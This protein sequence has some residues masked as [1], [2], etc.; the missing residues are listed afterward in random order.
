[1]KPASN[2][3]PLLQPVFTGRAALLMAALAY[4]SAS[5]AVIQKAN[6]ATD[7]NLAG[8]WTGGVVPG[9]AD[10]A[11][12][13]STVTGANSV[14]L[15]ADL[16]WTGIQIANP[17]GAVTVAG[18]NT[19]TLGTGGI[20]LSTATQDLTINAGL[21]LGD[22]KHRTWN[23][24][25]GRIL[26]LG[27]AVIR[28]A[29]ATVNVSGTGTVNTPL[30][31]TN[32][33]VGPWLT[34]GG[35]A[36]ATD[37]GGFL[38]ALDP[39]DSGAVSAVP[40]ASGTGNF[41]VS[42][43]GTRT[44]VLTVNTIRYTGAGAATFAGSGNNDFIINGLMN[45]GAGT[46]IITRTG[47]GRF[48]ANDAVN[49]EIVFNAATGDINIQSPFRAGTYGII[50]TGPNVVLLNNNASDGYTGPTRINQGIL[51][52]AA[53]T[54]TTIGNNSAVSLSDTAGAGL[55][56]QTFA[57]TI[58][59]LAGGGANGGNVT[60]TT[61]TLTIAG[62]NASPVSYGGSLAL[63]TAGIIK[64]GPGTQI[65][66]GVNTYTGTT[67][68]QNGVLQIAGG[69]LASPT[70]TLGNGTTSGKLVLGGSAGPVNQSFAT[71]STSGT[72]TANAVVGGAS[73]G[74]TLGLANSG[75]FALTL[76]GAGTNESNLGV[77]K[78]GPGTLSLTGSATMAGAT[79]I[80]EGM[81]EFGGSTP[82]NQATTG[83]ITVADSAALG[84]KVINPSQTRLSSGAL[85][86]GSADVTTLA[87]DFGGLANPTAPVINAAG[88][89]AVPG[90]SVLI[91]TNNVVGLTSGTIKLI[92]YTGAALNGTQFSKFILSNPN[93]GARKTASLV[94]NT[95]GTS[96]DLLVSADNPTWRGTV[97]NGQ[98]G[99]DWDIDNIGDGSV[100]T[101]NWAVAGG[102]TT[103]REIFPDNDSVVFDDTATGS[104]NVNIVAAVSPASILVNNAAKTYT[105][106]GANIGG[107][108]ILTKSGNG[109]LILANSGTAPSGG[110]QITGGTVK[111]G[112]FFS[113]GGQVTIDGGSFDLNGFDT[114]LDVLAGAGGSITNSAAGASTLTIGGGS[115]YTGTITDGGAGKTLAIT[116]NA[117][118]VALGGTNTYSG[119]TTLSG[120][121]LQAN[122]NGAL[123]S[124]AI[125]ISTG[126][127]FLNNGVNL[128][129]PLTITGGGVTG[130]GVVYVPTASTS[131]T[132]SGPINITGAAN[133]GGHFAANSTGG[134]LN[135]TGVITS[136]VPVSVRNGV[137]VFSN[138][139]SSYPQIFNNG[140]GTIRLGANNAIPTTSTVDISNVG[141]LDLAGFNQTLPSITSSGDPVTNSVV[142]TSTLTTT[143][144]YDFD[145][146]LQNGGT[147][148]LLALNVSSGTVKLLRANT[149]TGGTTIASG[150]TV[151]VN[152]ANSV[153][154]TG[155]NVALSGTLDLSNGAGTS[156]NLS[157]GALSG[158]GTVT[159]SAAGAATFTSGGATN[160]SFSGVIQNG[161]GVTSLTK[162]GAGILELS[163][164][165]TYS[166]NTQLGTA[167]GAGGI[168]ASVSG[169]LGSGTLLFDGSGGAAPGGPTSRLELVNGITLTNAISLNQRNNASAAI[170]NVSGS[171]T[172]SGAIDIA[173]GGAQANIQSDAGQL[174]LS[175][176]IATSIATVRNLHLG[177]AGNGAANGIISNGASS[178]TVTKEGSGTWT[179]TAANTYTGTTTVSEGTLSI[180]QAVLAD[181]AAVNIATAGVLNLTHGTSDTVDSL[182]IDGV[183]QAAGT[184]GSLSSSATNKTARITGSG[185]L[186]VSKGAVPGG[187]STWAS[188]SGL[189]TGVNDGA[190]QNPDNDGFDNGTEYILGGNPL[191]GSNNPKVYTFLADTEADVDALKELV[192]TIAVPAGTPAF[193]TAAPSTATFDGFAI[194]VRGGTDLSSFAATVTP[195]A[196]VTTGLPAAPVQGG[197]TY[198][199]RS[200]S[201]G[202]SNG[203]PTKGFLQVRVTP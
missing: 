201:L 187:F 1:M 111:L 86:F 156:I 157:V 4:S 189:T 155:G 55:D 59:S 109:T 125:S 115:T 127:L 80:A 134:V 179:L 114:T 33:I 101:P 36:W 154:G 3:Y 199:Y 19:L 58:G 5:A 50:K 62:N 203:T 69:S 117:G 107:S 52:I 169:A 35:S 71:V 56:L 97:S 78:T 138:T 83:N 166:G 170:L 197:I 106:S 2:S 39:A 8:S 92:D 40:T 21:T 165:N 63:G 142:G 105:I 118:A 129:N 6:N 84:V 186:S 195:V 45:S 175:G 22:N 18:A 44:G 152:N 99:A 193:T 32:G 29:G 133:A 126:Q 162:S 148:M 14:N 90:S 139:G 113:L 95:A 96:L 172:L 100:G 120:G 43:G 93:L 132:Y 108:G 176:P 79:S 168:R 194:Q 146:V 87:V 104:T 164:A 75:T 76:G 82:G 102:P 23:I 153:G 11:S 54:N 122:S 163:N 94:N 77:V 147:D 65:L 181:A 185:I 41:D 180:S 103:Y 66:T 9:S 17:G 137:V 38:A 81:L 51:R 124:G 16:S 136:T 144:T 31:N 7:L 91:N 145:G 73:T 119:G 151:Q 128:S 47:S 24:P 200:F 198:E 161:A 167:N 123:G 184:W 53:S 46:L 28:S 48:R 61:A 135:I 112:A 25:A 88:A 149:F 183:Q 202:V 131:A 143:G 67:A 159:N 130:Q 173:G 158:A 141:T 10:V 85:S 150:A 98:G 116:K 34:Y 20:D 42:L 26:T 171:N 121:T 178:V 57:Q 140:G 174:T 89:L 64:Q 177:G 68:V 15:G 13:S 70:L 30:L 190:A 60:G 182:F 196:P 12:W 191:S 192:V 110:T 27:G 188:A 160:S 72:G 49:G 37:A 74:S